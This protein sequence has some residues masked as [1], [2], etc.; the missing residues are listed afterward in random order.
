MTSRAW[1]SL[2][3]LLLSA[4]GAFAQPV[5]STINYQGRLTDNTP[6]QAPVTGTVSMRFEIF[7][8]QVGGAPL[9]QEPASGGLAV[10]VNDGLFSLVLGSTVPLPSSLFSGASSTR[11][12]QLTIDPGA[13]AEE[14]LA[15]RQL[16]SAT[17]YACRADDAASADDAAQLGGVDPSGYV[18][19][20]GSYA[21][22]TWITSLAAAKISGSV[23][24]ADALDGLD[25]T[26]FAAAAHPHAG[27]DITS[28]TVDEAVLDSAWTTKGL[29]AT[30]L[31]TSS[32]AAASLDVAGGIN[33]GSGNVGIVNSTGKIPA[34]SSTYF[35]N[36]DGSA[37]TNVGPLR[38]G[39][40]VSDLGGGN[41]T[42]IS[43]AI[44]VDGLPAIAA[45]DATA[46]DLIFFHCNDLACTSR[47][48][49]VLETANSGKSCSLAIGADGYPLI[50]YYDVSGENLVVTHCGAVDCSK[51]VVKTFVD[52]SG[53]TG[54]E[55]SL[56][57]GADGLGLI[58]YIGPSNSLKIAHCSNVTCSS[59][60][61]VSPGLAGFTTAAT[62]NIHGF[63]VVANGDNSSLDIL[64]C[65]N[66]TCSSHTAQFFAQ[67]GSVQDLSLVTAAD[68]TNLVGYYQFSALVLSTG[69]SVR[70]P[71]LTGDTGRRSSITV[72]PDGL[73]LVTYYDVANSALKL[74]RCTTPSCQS[75]AIGVVTLDNTADVGTASSVAIGVDGLPIVAFADTTN[76]RLKVMH[77]A[78]RFGLPFVRPR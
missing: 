33:A 62:I 40:S 22:P 67:T 28:G 76:Q 55:P 66:L 26:A 23:P 44:G 1:P 71:D 77:L 18:Q 41:Y 63:G 20:A 56:V 29:V 49:V 7:D 65:T 8:A 10:S 53:T 64:T 70:Y 46:G 39:H 12:L 19:T 51:S 32:T 37:L 59:A 15:P 3:F 73:P 69:S 72:G 17:A 14:I 2:L 9:W 21:D 13:P 48:G 38:P 31:A 36:L 68:G 60:T 30:T 47:S 45:F 42:H 4:A 25:S 34:I 43:M 27:S 11:Y 16:L 54:Q 52:S 50:A 5:P 75:G 78:N 24:N 6:Q 61:F 35:A 57:I 74:A 58:S